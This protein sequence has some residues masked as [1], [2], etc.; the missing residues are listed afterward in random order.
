MYKLKIF[1]LMLTISASLT[2]GMFTLSAT[3]N[4]ASRM[5]N[6]AERYS[7]ESIICN[8]KLN[9]MKET[10]QPGE[11]KSVPVRCFQNGTPLIEE[12]APRHRG[13]LM[14]K[15]KDGLYISGEKIV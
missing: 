12:L 6:K 11:K 8:Y 15:K 13:K 9:K 1:F 4:A 2:I 14:T 10:M 5:E 7:Q 3:G